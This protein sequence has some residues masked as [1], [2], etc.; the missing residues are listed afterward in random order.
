V[1]EPR[2]TRPLVLHALIVAGMLVSAACGAGPRS[3]AAA[4]EAFPAVVVASFSFPESEVLAEI[5]AQALE[6]VGV[7]VR[8]ELNLG[9]RELVQPALRQGL[10]D[11]VPEYL[12]S[13]L[14]SLAPQAPV[15]TRDPAA[16]RS[17][18][19][20]ALSG[21]GLR[22]LAPAAASDQNGLV[23]TSETADR[24][25]L[26]TISDLHGKEQKLTLAAPPECPIRPYC[27]QGLRSVYGLRF[28]R[29]LAFETETQRVTALNER[30][31]D[32]ALLFTTDG[33]LATG[34]LVLL[35]DDRGLQPAENLVPIVT[36]RAVERYG[37]RVVRALDSVSAR[38]NTASLVF[39]N[40]RVTVAGKDVAG[41]ARGWLRRHGLLTRPA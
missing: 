36:S 41:E 31:V 21:W 6:H 2:T 34:D 9:P 16:V 30:V 17:A 14:S 4:P 3:E 37:D 40:W 24:L 15:D 1:L 29:F 19:E 8:R 11:V 25:G 10:V 23:V 33:H 38:L 39:L 22:V 27:L 18:L 26:H 5:Y 13:A 35:R 12:G 28:A 20:R 7:P 32:V